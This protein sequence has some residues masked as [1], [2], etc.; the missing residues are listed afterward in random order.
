MDVYAKFWGKKVL[1]FFFHELNP[2]VLLNLI[3]TYCIVG[4]VTKRGLLE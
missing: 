3:C 4:V 1:P 2:T